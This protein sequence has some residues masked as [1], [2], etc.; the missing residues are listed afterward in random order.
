VNPGARTA[1]EAG[2]VPCDACGL[3][4][5]PAS[6]GNAET[7]PRCGESLEFRKPDSVQRTW[8]LVVAAA[9]CYLPA[10]VLPVMVTSTLRSVEESTILGGVVHFYESGSWFL[11]LIVLTAS[12]VIPL[13]KLAALAYLLLAVRRPPGRKSLE[14]A[15]LYR[16]LS[17]IGRWSMLDVFV[18][19]FVVALVQFE[20]F[21][22]VVP[23]PGV[24]FFAAVV[25]LTLLA[26]ETFDPRLIW[27]TAGKSGGKGD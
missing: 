20:P 11:A 21:L 6:P 7:C 18:V 13:G 3:L 12:V 22:S 4:S 27:D 26:A 10:N 14:R 17:A 24:L 5:R 9:V 2:I 23:G 25:I 1:A 19:A 16:L 15:R 8:A